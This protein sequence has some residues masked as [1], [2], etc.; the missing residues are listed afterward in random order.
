MNTQKKII[1]FFFF[2][3]ED[4]GLAFAQVAPHPPAFSGDNDRATW[5]VAASETAG[6]AGEER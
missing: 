1:F 6:A 4:C 2:I 3:W 5:R